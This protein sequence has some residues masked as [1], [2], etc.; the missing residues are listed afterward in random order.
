MDIKLNGKDHQ[1]V[2]GSTSL[3]SLLS[4][5]GLDPAMPGIAVAINF[6]VIPRSQWPETIIEAGDEIE[7]ITARQGG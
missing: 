4:N 3:L 5:N 2:E 1:L 6:N 7:L